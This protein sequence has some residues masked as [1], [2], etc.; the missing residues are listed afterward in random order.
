MIK[1]KL[2]SSK[3]NKEKPAS[4][5]NKV[6]ADIFSGSLAVCFSSSAFWRGGGKGGSVFSA[7]ARRAR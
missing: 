2:K 6:R 3:E 4:G 1:N 7:S 5:Q